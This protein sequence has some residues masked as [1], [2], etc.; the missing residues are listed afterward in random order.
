[1]NFCKDVI[2]T[3]Q[4]YDKDQY[5]RKTSMWPI[6]PQYDLKSNISCSTKSTNVTLLDNNTGQRDNAQ[7]PP[8]PMPKISETH[9][10]YTKVLL[11][12]ELIL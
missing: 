11:P 10:Y 8:Q 4:S 1:M 7:V 5:K 12:P 3:A 6:N 2:Y 9:L